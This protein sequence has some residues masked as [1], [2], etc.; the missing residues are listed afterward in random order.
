MK[1]Q[2]CRSRL[3]SQLVIGVAEKSNYE[4]GKLAAL[5]TSWTKGTCKE[6]GWKN[7]CQGKEDIK[8]LGF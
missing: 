6:R 8:T 5:K 7:E 3:V 1:L 4:M 2:I